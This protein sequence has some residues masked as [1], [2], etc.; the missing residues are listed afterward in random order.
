MSREQC[1]VVQWVAGDRKTPT[2]HR[3]GKHHAR[4]IG[5]EIALAVRLEQE[6]DVVSAEVLY[7]WGDFLVTHLFHESTNLVGCTFEELLAQ[8]GSLQGEEALVALVRHV[9]DV[10]AQVFA[11]WLGKSS[12]QFLAVLGL[13]HVPTGIGEELCEFLDLHA[14]HH[15][16]EALAIGIDDPH[17]VAETLQ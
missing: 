11:E 3:V 1:G 4:S 5:D 6:R 2:F 9:V 12:L 17:H 10:M 16:V 7:E 15:S 8:V 14:R 13:H